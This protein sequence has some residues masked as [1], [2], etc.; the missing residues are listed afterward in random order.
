MKHTL[1]QP[2]TRPQRKARSHDEFADLTYGAAVSAGGLLDLAALSPTAAQSTHL[3][4]AVLLNRYFGNEASLLVLF[5]SFVAAFML[6][7]AALGGAVY[8]VARAFSFGADNNLALPYATAFVLWGVVLLKRWQRKN[9][10]L[11]F[12]CDNTLQLQCALPSSLSLSGFSPFLCLLC[13][14]DG[15]VVRRD[16]SMDRSPH[17][18]PRHVLQ[19]IL[20]GLREGCAMPP[21]GRSCSLRSLHSV[22]LQ[23]RIVRFSLIL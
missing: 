14:A 6:P 22:P 21:S 20:S 2:P 5:M 12:Y 3:W 8:L 7:P 19:D 23:F 15:C 10:E 11:L 17:F 9:A 16:A 13:L 18:R 4:P 1:P